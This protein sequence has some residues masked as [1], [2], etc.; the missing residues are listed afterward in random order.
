M[1]L[2]ELH[3]LQGY[4]LVWNTNKAAGQ[5]LFHSHLHVIPHFEDEPLTA[6]KDLRSFINGVKENKRNV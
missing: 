1:P 6:G 5:H 4:N 2:D 3:Q